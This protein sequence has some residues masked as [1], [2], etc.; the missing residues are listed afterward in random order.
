MGEHTKIIPKTVK[1][2]SGDYYEINRNDLIVEMIPGSR[3]LSL[4]GVSKKESLT[5]S[6]LVKIFKVF[7]FDGKDLI[8]WQIIEGV[9]KDSFVWNFGYEDKKI[10]KKIF[11]DLNN[12]FLEKVIKS[13]RK[14][15][16]V[17]SINEAQKIIFY[18]E[19]SLKD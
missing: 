13:K 14:L 8:S 1:T 18:K 4:E 5:R 10:R 3:I 9:M 6:C 12:L 2:A 19:L 16:I 7:D 11:K 17:V 15:I